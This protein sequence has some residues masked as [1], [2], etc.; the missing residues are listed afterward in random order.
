VSSD[1]EVRTASRSS[2]PGGATV[3]TLDSAL[4]E[5]RRYRELYPD[6]PPEVAAMGMVRRADGWDEIR[7]VELAVDGVLR[8]EADR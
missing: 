6:T 2:G 8:E 4:A 7:A 3:I 1:V 5:L